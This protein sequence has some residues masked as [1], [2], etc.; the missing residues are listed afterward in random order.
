M[1]SKGTLALAVMVLGLGT[2]YCLLYLEEKGRALRLRYEI[3]KLRKRSRELDNEISVLAAKVA[4]VHSPAH[5]DELVRE[6]NLNLLP[7][8][9]CKSQY[10][11]QLRKQLQGSVVKEKPTLVR[12]RRALSVRRHAQR[13]SFNRRRTKP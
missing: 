4:E 5:V 11:A 8:E 13:V 12:N 1:K 6:A 2:T 9:Q 7:L 3:S 10:Y